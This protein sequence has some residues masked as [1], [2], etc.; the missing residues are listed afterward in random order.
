MTG[1][2][3]CVCRCTTDDSLRMT[4]AGLD[5]ELQIISSTSQLRLDIQLRD[6]LTKYSS[7]VFD[8]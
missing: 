6:A 1:I 5:V 4:E 3:Q 2:F 8:S 7:P